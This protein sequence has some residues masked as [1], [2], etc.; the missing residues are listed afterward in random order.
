[1]SGLALLYKL[2]FHMIYQ[3]Y[4]WF[5]QMRF[6]TV[7]KK[8]LLCVTPNKWFGWIP[9]LLQYIPYEVWNSKLDFQLEKSEKPNLTLQ[10]LWFLQSV[11]SLLFICAALNKPH[12]ELWPASTH[13]RGTAVFL[14]AKRALHC[15]ARDAWMALPCQGTKESLLFRLLLLETMSNQEWLHS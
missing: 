8:T 2:K 5:F 10:V 1:M 15:T 6:K 12:K 9:S 3:L 7:W 13:E 14:S 11:L 4:I